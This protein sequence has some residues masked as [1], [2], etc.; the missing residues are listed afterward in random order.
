MRLHDHC[1]GSLILFHDFL[2]I[3]WLTFYWQLVSGVVTPKD[4]TLLSTPWDR[5]DKKQLRVVYDD[6]SDDTLSKPANREKETRN[7]PDDE[8]RFGITQ[9]FN[10]VKETESLI[11]PNWRVNWLAQE[12]RFKL[13]RHISGITSAENTRSISNAES[14]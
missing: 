2:I 7:L 5:N 11:D 3:Y 1:L 12:K 6:Y 9:D 4:W 13:K 14:P 8:S 10:D